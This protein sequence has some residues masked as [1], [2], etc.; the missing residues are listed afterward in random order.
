M[1][2][3]NNDLYDKVC[4][5]DGE[6]YEQEWNNCVKAYI[7]E[8]ELN[9]NRLPKR[10]LKEYYKSHMHDYEVVQISFDR[11]ELKSRYKYNVSIKLLH[12]YRKIEHILICK[13]VK[14]FKSD[15]DNADFRSYDLLYSE[16]LVVN[17]KLMSFEVELSE[18]SSFKLIF[19]KLAYRKNKLK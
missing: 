9:A 2:Y 4:S 10:F 5:I 13:D 11:V 14:Y 19:S 6:C 12:N 15:M 8:L 7:K 1:K 16:I 3:L 18:N 17:E